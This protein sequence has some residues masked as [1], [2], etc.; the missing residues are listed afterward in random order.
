MQQEAPDA[1]KL[2]SNYLIPNPEEFA[3]NLLKAYEVGSEALVRLT[4]R[5]D[6][7]SGPYS[8]ASEVS[9]ATKTLGELARL[10]LADPARLAE[11]QGEAFRRF[12]ELWNNVLMRMFGMPV[13]PLIEPAPG[14]N[15]F[16]DPEWTLNPF[17]DFCK[18]AYLLFCKWAEDRLA[19]TQGLSDRDR[20]RAEFYLRQVT[21]AYSPS[22][23]LATNPEVLRET[24][25]TNAANLVEGVKLLAN[26][27]ERSTD[28]MR[29]SQT[30]T[31]A[32][33]LGK[34]LATT[35]GKVV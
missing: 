15:R 9:V 26:D 24:F 34:N 19:E 7:T 6:A 25:R 14:D 4:E 33:E 20:H 17:F 23:F 12:G 30:D 10:W 32:F 18:Q 2:V 16:K 11:A 5:P 8:P 27:M 21:S 28:L 13:S 22:N 29:I 31:S 3:S 1:F 35:P